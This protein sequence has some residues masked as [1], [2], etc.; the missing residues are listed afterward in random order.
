VRG[1]VLR[2]GDA[3]YDDARAIQNGLIGRHPALIVRCSGTADVIQEVNFARTHNLVLPARL[4]LEPLSTRESAPKRLG[5]GVRGHI[6]VTRRLPWRLEYLI[7]AVGG[8]TLHAHRDMRVTVEGDLD[9]TVPKALLHNLRMN[10]LGQHQRRGGVPKVVEPN[11]RQARPI[12]KL[13]EP[14]VNATRRYGAA[15]G[16]GEN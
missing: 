1:A 4:L 3:D 9:R 11:S 13:P 8:L 2:P 12:S 15:V 7:E 14:L 10:T 5:L 16:S 6:E